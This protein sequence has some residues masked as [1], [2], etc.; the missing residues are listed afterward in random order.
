MLV[1]TGHALYARERVTDEQE[2]YE[3]SV[4]GDFDANVWDLLGPWRARDSAT[5]CRVSTS[6]IMWPQAHA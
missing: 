5:S 1:P 4:L 6:C 2:G 3:F